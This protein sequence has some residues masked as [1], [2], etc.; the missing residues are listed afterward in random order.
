VWDATTT[1]GTRLCG[2]SL[3][4]EPTGQSEDFVISVDAWPLRGGRYLLT[5]VAVVAI[6]VTVVVSSLLGRWTGS[7]AVLVVAGLV[8]LFVIPTLALYALDRWQRS[9][10]P[11][12]ELEVSRAI[13]SLISRE[14]WITSRDR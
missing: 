9:H 11:A 6:A 2:I 4:E 3:S 13:A 12:I 8:G 14:T 1:E 7:T 5:L 10:P